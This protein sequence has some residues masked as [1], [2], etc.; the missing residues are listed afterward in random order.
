MIQKEEEAEI[1]LKKF[2]SELAIFEEAYKKLQKQYPPEIRNEMDIY[3]KVEQATYIKRKQM[4]QQM[5][6]TKELEEKRNK[7]DE[8]KMIVRG[9][10]NAGTAVQMNGMHWS[11]A[12]SVKNVTVRR[13]FKEIGVFRRRYSIRDIRF[14]RREASLRPC[15]F[16]KT[17]IQRRQLC[18]WT[19]I[20]LEKMGARFW[21][22]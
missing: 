13:S 7:A 2:Q 6:R 1:K 20:C 5:E 10:L 16:W 14:C 4:E 3:L 22:R 19:G 15:S 18:C 11:A 21:R 8:A 9:T 17:I 12:N